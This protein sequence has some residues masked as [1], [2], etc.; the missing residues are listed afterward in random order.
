[1]ALILKFAAL[2]GKLQAGGTIPLTVI[3]QE[4]VLLPSVVFTV[5]V[6]VPTALAVT[7]PVEASTV[8]IAVF[9]EDHDTAG[10]VALVGEIVEAKST[11]PPTTKFAVGQLSIVTPVT[12]IFV[13][14]PSETMLLFETE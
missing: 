12:G 13:V 5:I 8:A 2:Q 6:A 3:P 10:F 11:V 7:N 14:P 9:E 4:V 1:V